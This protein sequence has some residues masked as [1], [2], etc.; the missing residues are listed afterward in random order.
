MPESDRTETVPAGEGSKLQ[1]ALKQMAAAI[2]AESVHARGAQLDRVARATIPDPKKPAALVTPKDSA[3][4]VQVVRI[5]S[6]YGVALWPVSQ[7]RNWGYGSATACHDNAVVLHL[8][9]L[10][11]I[12][13]V[14][15]ELAYAVIEPGVTYRQLRTF[16]E[17][18]HPDLWC[19]CTDGPPDGS[20]IGNA[21]DR[22][23]GVTHYADHFGTL[24]GLEVVLPTGDVIRTGGGPPDCQTWHT[25]KWGV[26]PHTEGL[27][28]QSNLGIVTR[29]GVWLIRKPEAFASF[30][31][32]LAR[33]ADLPRLVDTV[34]ELALRGVL[35]SA[36]HVV[37]DVVAL[38]VL[39]QYPGDL[40]DRHSRLPDD[41]LRDLCRRYGVAPWSLGG[42]IQ[43]TA[44]TVREVKRQLRRALASLGR[45]TF[46][47]DRSV[48]LIS[49]LNQW[50]ARSA[51]G[52]SVARWVA[53][54]AG[55]SPEMLQ[56]AP[57]IHSVL[58]GIPS[59][60]FVRHAYFKSRLPKPEL[61]D[62][63]RDDCGLVWFAPIAPMTGRHVSEL[64]RL[65]E[66]LFEQHR[67]DFYAALLM[68]NARSMIVLM[69][70]FFLKDDPEQVLRAKR[71]YEELC[72]ATTA[73]GYQQYRIG[74]GG[75]DQLIASTPEF[76]SFARTLKAAVDP[77]KILAP[78]KYGIR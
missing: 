56:A 2:G 40:L 10:N 9:R 58:K 60:Y 30:T 57:H 39:T 16:L 72:R 63:D 34:R 5:A 50:S 61:A 23:L 48:G 66:P 78:G 37:N 28:S 64:L 24:C 1:A 71:L 11:Q 35:Q 44:A 21:L 18:H 46:L 62:P 45:L 68:Q 49:R 38:C 26:G 41:V 67:F 73:D 74:V 8:G 47:D 75:M 12:L 6:Q 27:F 20:V 54:A 53:G 59:D 19:D 4:V 29:A 13:E 7:G 51:A 25:H 3:D 14:N 43:G 42:G 31:F 65:C 32:D 55:K 52:R 15:E 33:V 36:C 70:I 69:S 17:L 22:G 76:V 77:S